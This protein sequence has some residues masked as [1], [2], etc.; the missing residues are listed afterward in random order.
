[1]A[2]RS[3]S[4]DTLKNSRNEAKAVSL[5]SCRTNS[6]VSIGLS[7][8]PAAGLNAEPSASIAPGQN[9]VVHLLEN[10]KLTATGVTFL[11]VAGKIIGVGFTG[12]AIHIGDQVLRS[13]T[14][15]PFVKFL[16]FQLPLI[17]DQ[18]LDL[19]AEFLQT[20][21]QLPERRV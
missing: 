17:G 18:S 11:Q 9:R 2:A 5:R 21:L 14:N 13:M 7:T 3:Q 8:G 19:L 12:F 20:H 6:G 10:S 15:W 16:P 4:G 1:M